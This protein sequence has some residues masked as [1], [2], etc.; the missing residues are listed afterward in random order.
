MVLASLVLV[1]VGLS[2]ANLELSEKG[3]FGLGFAMALFSVVAVQKNV[4]DLAA[5]GPAPAV[6]KPPVEP[7]PQANVWH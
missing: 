5:S 2:N 7:D 1:T 4:R 6:Q 3:F